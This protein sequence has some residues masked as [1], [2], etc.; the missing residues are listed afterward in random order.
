MKILASVQV[1]FMQSGL[2]Q[3]R[4]KQGETVCAAAKSPYLPTLQ[5]ETI[6][7]ANQDE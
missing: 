7:S 4:F 5:A 2:V 3:Q 1:T 6:T